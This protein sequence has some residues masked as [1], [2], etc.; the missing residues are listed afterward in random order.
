MESIQAVI[1][2]LGRVLV[3]V[4]VR[5][6]Q[7]FFLEQTGVGDTQ[8]ALTHIMANPMMAQF[9]TGQIEPRAFY[10]GLCAEYGLTLSFEEF[11][12][13]WCDIFSSMNGIEDIVEA[14]SKKV[15]LGLLSNTDPLHW[16]Y[17]KSH[18]PMMRYFPSPTLSFE[19]GVM[20]PHP[21]IYAQ[22]AKNAGVTP[23]ECYFADDLAE[24]VDG[25]AAAGMTT[26]RFEGVE[27]FRNELK[28]T[29][30]L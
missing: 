17:V 3:D 16:G 8:Q 18:Y 5:R 10:Q 28:K 30:I 19:V 25:A 20:K 26:I 14:L 27:H 29:G 7:A 23:A 2:D 11:A 21:A 12:F 15:K 4:N 13:R 6:L 1:F 9:N 24:N 22:A